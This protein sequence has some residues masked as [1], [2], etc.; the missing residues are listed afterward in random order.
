MVVG[1]IPTE[2]ALFFTDKNKLLP[3]YRLLTT[4]RKKRTYSTYDSRVVP[5]HST[6]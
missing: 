4:K 1:S 3:L 2:G 6:R 5:H